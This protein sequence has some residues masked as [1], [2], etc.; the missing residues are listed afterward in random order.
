MNARQAVGLPAAQN[1]APGQ[2]GRKI[3]RL[4]APVV[5]L[6]ESCFIHPLESV[7]LY[8]AIAPLPPQ[9]RCR[10]VLQPEYGASH[11]CNIRM[12]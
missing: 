3:L 11:P 4:L 2:Q 1:P 8:A 9:M 7:S 6:P 12:G 5:T 10:G